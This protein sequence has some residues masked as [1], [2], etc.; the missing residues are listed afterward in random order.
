MDGRPETPAV[1]CC[2]DVFVP[3]KLGR[4]P[5]RRQAL[6]A[7]TT[8][9]RKPRSRASTPVPS[10]FCAMRVHAFP[11][12]KVAKLGSAVPIEYNIFGFEVA[13]DHV[14]RVEI[15]RLST[16]PA[17]LVDYLPPIWVHKVALSL[18]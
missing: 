3:K 1:Y 12:A 5:R 17:S 4:G 10:T 11:T 7:S 14:H 9:V 15:F 18:F 13:V 8:A 16:R 2:R 6:R